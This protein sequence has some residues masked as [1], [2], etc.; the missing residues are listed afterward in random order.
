MAKAKG[1]RTT[2]AKQPKVRT[3]EQ[4]FQRGA[5]QHLR[6]SLRGAVV[7]HA[8]N[9]RTA[10][11]EQGMVPGYPDLLVH[12][13]G[14][15]FGVELKAEGNDLRDEQV[16]CHEQLREA[17]VPVFTVW[18][19]T[20]LAEVVGWAQWQAAG[21]HRREPCLVADA[22]R[23]TRWQREHPAWTGQRT[24]GPAPDP[25]GPSRAWADPPGDGGDG[26]RKPKR[27]RRRPA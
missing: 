15:T 4:E 25:P 20:Q 10:S 22:H 13:R 11:K 26:D 6:L 18:D 14:L 3:A 1:Q 21:N 2:Y 16:E 7:V 8:A 5:V 23:A 24:D 17:G 19:L 9:E 12:W 27:K